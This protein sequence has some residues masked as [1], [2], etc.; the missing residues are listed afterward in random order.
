MAFGIF[1]ILA[2]I[3]ALIACFRK[4]ISFKKALL[5]FL[6]LLAVFSPRIFFEMRHNFLVTKN[7]LNFL[8]EKG[9]AVSGGVDLLGRS[10]E[11]LMAF[12][13]AWHQTLA[14]GNSFLGLILL[15]LGIISLVFLKKYS[16]RTEKRIVNFLILLILGLYLLFSLYSG[17]FWSYYLIGLPTLYILLFIFLL[18][19]LYQVIQRKIFL[20]GLI[21]YFIFLIQPLKMIDAFRQ[22]DWEGDAAVYRNVKF[23]VEEV[24]QNADGESFDY[25][26]YTPPL[27]P[28][29]YEYLFTWLSEKEYH[30]LPRPESQLLYF[31]VE[32]NAYQPDLPEDWLLAHDGDADFVFEKKLKGGIILQKRRRE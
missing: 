17:D 32:P 4:E 26:V 3:F 19:R 29:T 8:R 24:F 14:N 25:L 7:V 31:I 15:I 2:E 9:L 12:I 16:S 28:Y 20:L 21:L 27:I 23:A 5:F 10:Q 13:S 22:P 30:N 11:R 1:F 18:Y 6:G